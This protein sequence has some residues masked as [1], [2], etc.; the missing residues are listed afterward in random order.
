MALQRSLTVPDTANA[1]LQNRINS[2]I[3]FNYCRTHGVAHRAQIARDLRISAPAVSRAVERLFREGYLIESEK[4]RIENG[5]MAAQ[6]SINAERGIIIGMDLLSDPV[7]IAV[8]DFAGAILHSRK[9]PPLD[10]EA[11]YPTFIIQAVEACL[12]SFKREAR[13]LALGIG[14]PAAVD[15]ADGHILSAGLYKNVAPAGFRERIIERFGAP[16]YIEN[17]SNLAAIGEWKRG[18]GQGSRNMLFVEVS[19]GIGAGIIL[20]GDLHRGIQG[21]AGEIGYFLTQSEALG[22]DSSRKGCL[23]SIASLGALRKRALELASAGLLAPGPDPL[24]SLCAAA[25]AGNAAAG[26]AIAEAV[27]HLAVAVVNIMILLNP[28]IVVIGGGCCEHPET[29]AMIARP[30][31]EAVL[32]NYPFQPANVRLASLGSR[33]SVIGALQFALD[34]LVVQAYPYRL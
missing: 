9:G 5:K 13:I 7:E 25:E 6:V 24:A 28:E 4:V 19:N 33:T 31:I 8:S 23:E 10:E 12:E 17:I 16:V 2:S 29:E 21:S 20:D 15:P 11:D 32:R 1:N 14:V 30:L 3:I 27:A 34:S 22:H 26:E 18:V